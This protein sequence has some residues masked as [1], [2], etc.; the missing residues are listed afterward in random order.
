MMMGL[1]K[2]ADCW[3]LHPHIK[4]KDAGNNRG[5]KDR[6]RRRDRTRSKSRETEE[7]RTKKKGREQSPYPS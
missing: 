1:Y 5:G 6:G 3:V 2:E 4:P 7:G